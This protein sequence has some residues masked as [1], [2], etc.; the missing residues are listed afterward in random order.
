MIIINNKL[1][2]KYPTCPYIAGRMCLRYNKKIEVKNKRC[3]ISLNCAHFFL[4][5]NNITNTI[6]PDYKI[7]V[8]VP[9][10]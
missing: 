10:T 7:L 3:S 5:Y 6:K 2:G 9:L 4:I 1:K 8:D